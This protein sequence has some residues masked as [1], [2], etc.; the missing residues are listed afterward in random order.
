MGN[1]VHPTPKAVAPVGPSLANHSQP[2][3]LKDLIGIGGGCHTQNKG[4]KLPPIALNQDG[5][6][7]DFAGFVPIQQILVAIFHA[8]P[9]E[10]NVSVH[11]TNQRDEYFMEFTG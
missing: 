5:Q 7:S 3:V 8:I 1:P 11:T 6:G 4:E 9:F 10:S 2:D